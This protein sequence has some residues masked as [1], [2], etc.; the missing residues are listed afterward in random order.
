MI[1]YNEIEMEKFKANINN[2]FE[3]SNLR[4]FAYFLEIEIVKKKHVILLHQKK[5]E[6]KYFEEGII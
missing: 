5:Y 1:G 3:M 2:E 6:K 4:N